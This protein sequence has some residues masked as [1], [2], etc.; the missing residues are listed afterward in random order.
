MGYPVTKPPA[1]EG[2]YFDGHAWFDEGSEAEYQLAE[3]IAKN[4]PWAS[5][6]T[7]FAT[8]HHTEDRLVWFDILTVTLDDIMRECAIP[9]DR[10][11]QHKKEYRS[12]ALCFLQHYEGS[13][14]SVP[15]LKE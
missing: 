9:E 8:G 14:R 13:Q 7:M 6:N 12:F 5:G 10:R 11:D 4:G 15:L 3:S 1:L 2:M